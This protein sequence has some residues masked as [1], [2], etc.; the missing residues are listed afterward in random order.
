MGHQIYYQTYSEKVNK[1]QVQHYWDNY[2]A[3]EDWQEG[4]TGLSEPHP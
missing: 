2:A 1:Q 3:H 4:C